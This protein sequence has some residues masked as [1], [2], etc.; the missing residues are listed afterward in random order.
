MLDNSALLITILIVFAVAVLFLMVA[1]G[2]KKEKQ[3]SKT[4]MLNTLESLKAGAESEDLARRRDT[5]IKLDN[6]LSRALQYR[7]GN[8]KLCGDNLKLIGKRFKKDEYNKLWEVHKMRNQIV[9]DDLDITESEG[10]EAYRIYN[11]S[12]RRILK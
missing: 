7:L 11:I 8:E 5:I 4:R 12:I 10:K 6:V 3:K 1:S 9:H 2:Q